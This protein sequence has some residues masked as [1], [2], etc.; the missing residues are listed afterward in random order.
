MVRALPPVRMRWLWFLAALVVSPGL[1]A[2]S[3]CEHGRVSTI[4]PDACVRITH[5]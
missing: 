5:A 3:S 1:L 4:E 2:R